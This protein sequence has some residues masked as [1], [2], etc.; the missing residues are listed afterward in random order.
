MSAA[1]HDALIM[2]DSE[3][4]VMFWNHAAES[5]FSYTFDEI[6]GNDMHS[7]FVPEEHHADAHAGL[8]KFAQTGQDRLLG[9]YKN[10]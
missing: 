5:M 3:G 4:R 9:L 10:K 6:R 2:I 7:L 8:K 1:V